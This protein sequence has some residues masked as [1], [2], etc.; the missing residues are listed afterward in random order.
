MNLQT[1]ILLVPLAVL[2]ILLLAAV[3]VR[4]N[5]ERSQ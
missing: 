2:A 5:Q 1:I 3:G 4:R